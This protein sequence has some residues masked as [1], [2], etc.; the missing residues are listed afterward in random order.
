[1]TTY[2]FICIFQGVALH[3]QSRIHYLNRANAETKEEEEEEEDMGESIL[4][5]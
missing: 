2:K 4:M 5:G 1:M 3:C